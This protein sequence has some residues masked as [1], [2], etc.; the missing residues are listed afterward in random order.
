MFLL[1][2]EVVVSTEAEKLSTIVIPLGTTWS[3]PI[4]G[5]KVYTKWEI[6]ANYH[7]VFTCLYVQLIAKVPSIYYFIYLHN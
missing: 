5:E 2:T 7:I 6:S 1:F 3:S 4:T